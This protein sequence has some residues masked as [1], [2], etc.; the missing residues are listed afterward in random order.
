MQNHLPQYLLPD[1]RGARTR[2]R[3]GFL[4]RNP[5]CTRTPAELGVIVQSPLREKERSTRS[6]YTT[7]R[8]RV[9]PISQ[10]TP[11]LAFGIPD[12]D[13]TGSDGSKDW[14]QGVWSR[15]LRSVAHWSNANLAC[16]RLATSLFMPH[17]FEPYLTSAASAS[18]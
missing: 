8:V 3:Y 5:D 10:C 12:H 7:A 13:S 16:P 18:T 14:L 2:D 17:M 15:F 9:A 4:G 11:K 1:P 6:R